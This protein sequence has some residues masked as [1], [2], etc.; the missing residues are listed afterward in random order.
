MRVS[1]LTLTNFRNYETAALDLLP[2]PTLFV[3]RNGQGK[4][5][6]V[7]SLVFI[8]TG[9]SHRVPHD[10]AMV[11]QGVEQAIIR[12]ELT[13]GAR[14]IPVDVQLN[15]QGANKAQAAGHAV[16]IGELSRYL[17]A[18]LFA[19]EDLALVRGEPSGRRRFLDML[20]TARAPRLA[21][22]L[23]D[24]D[25]VLKQRNSLLKSARAS[26]LRPE[27]LTTLDVWDER[28]VALGS[29]IAATRRSLVQDLEPHV[30]AAYRAVAGDDHSTALSIETNVPEDPDVYLHALRERRSDELDRGQS[31]IG[32]HRD[33]LVITLNGLL[34]RHYASH[35][36]SWS[37]ALS[38][39]LASAELMRHEAAGDPVVIL[40]DVFAELDVGRRERL[41]EAVAGFEQVLITA[42]VDDDVP[43]VLGGRRVRI[44][45]GSI[46]DDTGVPGGD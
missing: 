44:S 6:L 45:A 32:P 28:M 43:H 26:R 3:G 30:A 21:G 8:A 24:F 2:G 38:L 29:E 23:A 15:A 5:N 37:L 12:V 18:V 35:G 20:L 7:E 11:R 46:V 22:V 41:A 14:V 34:G 9:S 42:A 4:T 1:R 39:K 17:Q 10:I 31:L 40:D 27:Q 25:R 33:D 36:E 13:H 19:P 16:R